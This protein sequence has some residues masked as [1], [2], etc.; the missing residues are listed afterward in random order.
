MGAGDGVGLDSGAVV[1][2]ARARRAGI[3]TAV[4]AA[5]S[6]AATR[7][8]RIFFIG[9]LLFDAASSGARR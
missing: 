8:N 6:S 5:V 9:F 7:S 1:A 2:G 4:S 3:R